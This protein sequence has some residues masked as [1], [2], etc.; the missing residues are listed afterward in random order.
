ME[1]VLK[2]ILIVDD[3]KEI[4]RIFE[5]FFKTFGE[6]EFVFAN[7]G[8]EAF[9]HSYNQKFDLITL[10]HQMP[11]MNGASFL[12]ALRTKE[13]Q[14]KD[15]PVF[16]ISAFIPDIQ[17]SVKSINNTFFFDKPVNF[18]SLIRNA[19]MVLNKITVPDSL[20]KKSS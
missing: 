15:C 13:N 5:S 16:L 4:Q 20:E 19:K 18:D 6:F 3:E 7:D 9:A 10:D 8:L 12:Y 11:Y 1:E 14:N 2:R 17:E